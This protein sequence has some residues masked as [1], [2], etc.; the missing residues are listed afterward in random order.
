M[1]QDAFLDLQEERQLVGRQAEDRQEDQRRQRL[2]ERAEQLGLA[3]GDELVDERAG[4]RGDPLGERG[5]ALRREHGVDQLAEVGV[6]LAVDVERDQLLIAT[7]AASAAVTGDTSV[8]VD[9]HTL[10]HPRHRVPARCPL[11]HRT[12]PCVGIE[13]RL[14]IGAHDLADHLRWIHRVHQH[15]VRV[16]HWPR[17]TVASVRHKPLGR[18]VTA[19]ERCPQP[20][21]AGAPRAVRESTRSCACAT[22]WER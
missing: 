18:R 10:L 16:A 1:P 21:S 15:S 5:D 2:A 22:C 9:L 12:L 20:R 4:L 11:V 6:H 19:G 17:C 8:A 14:G 7:H 13:H 3:V